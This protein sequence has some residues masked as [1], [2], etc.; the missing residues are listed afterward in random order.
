MCEEIARMDDARD[1]AL[2][3]EMRAKKAKGAAS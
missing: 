3:A 2:L 1:A